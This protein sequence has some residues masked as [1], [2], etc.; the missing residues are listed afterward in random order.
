MFSADF[1]LQIESF[2][3]NPGTTTDAAPEVLR[4]RCNPVDASV[5]LAMLLPPLPPHA[6]PQLHR[7]LSCLHEGLSAMCDLIR[8]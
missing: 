8:A 3:S 4:R 6:Q 5:R 1:E 7:S 2:L